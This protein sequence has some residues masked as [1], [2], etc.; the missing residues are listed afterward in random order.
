MGL[1]QLMRKWRERADP[2]SNNCRVV[3][4]HEQ[5]EDDLRG[6]RLGRT[7]SFQ[8][9]NDPF[10]PRNGLGVDWLGDKCTEQ[11]ATN[12]SLKFEGVN[13]VLDLTNTDPQQIH[14]VQKMRMFW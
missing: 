7:D 4:Q 13:V 1:V 10:Y 14:F 12:N 3:C 6:E 8:H 9:C 2:V 5:V 11:N